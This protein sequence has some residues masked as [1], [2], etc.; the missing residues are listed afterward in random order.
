MI[1]EQGEAFFGDRVQYQPQYGYFS[2]DIGAPPVTPLDL[3][4]SQSMLPTNLLVSSPYI[5][6][7]H[8][9]VPMSPL[10]SVPYVQQGPGN[11]I[12]GYG[13]VAQPCGHRGYVY[14]LTPPPLSGFSSSN[15][16]RS[17]LDQLNISRTVVLKNLSDDLSLN[18]LL[19]VVDHGP[20]EYCK[21]FSR[22]T[23]PH[24]KDAH[25]LKTCYISFINSKLSVSFYLKYGKNPANLNSLKESL[26]N[27]KYLKVSLYEMNHNHS[28]V[29]YGHYVLNKQDF[30]KIKTLNYIVDLGATR[31]VNVNLRVKSFT[32]DD[33]TIKAF[34][35]K[36]G[37]FGE[38]EDFK[39][40]RGKD[41]QNLT[42]CIHFTSI[43]S[44]I[45]SY[46]YV[47]KLINNNT[48]ESGQ[49]KDNGTDMLVDGYIFVSFGKD[50][51]DRTDVEKSRRPSSSNYITNDSSL[52]MSQ[53]SGKDSTEHSSS[54][55]LSDVSLTAAEE[56]KNK[57]Y[58]AEG[59]D[60]ST[61]KSFK[62]LGFNDNHDISDPLLLKEDVSGSPLV[63]PAESPS[64]HPMDHT[65]ISRYPYMMQLNSHSSPSMSRSSTT[66]FSSTAFPYNPDPF[67]VGNRTIYLGNLHPSTTVEEIANNVRAGGLVESIKYHQ[68]KHMCF[69]TFVDPVVALKFY[70][71]HQVLHQL[72]IHGYSITVGW[73]KN[74]SGPLSR[75]IALAVTAGASRN[76]YIGIK[77]NKEDSDFS[78]T[79]KNSSKGRL[80]NESVL[81]RDFSK[82]G[83]L[84]QI[85]FYHNGDC[86]FLNFMHIMSAIKVVELFESGNAE[87]ISRIVGDNGKFYETY[88]DF[89][90]SFAKDRCGNPPKFNIRKKPGRRKTL[91]DEDDSKFLK[92]DFSFQEEKP[93]DN[94]SKDDFIDENAALVFGIIRKDSKEAVSPFE[95]E[96]TTESLDREEISK[97]TPARDRDATETTSDIDTTELSDLKI[98]DQFEKQEKDTTEDQK[99]ADTAVSNNQDSKKTQSSEAEEENADIDGEEYYEDDEE[100]D[101]DDDDDI[102]III[103]ANDSSFSGGHYQKPNNRKKLHEPR[104]HTSDSFV[105]KNNFSS[106]SSSNISL[107]SNDLK[108]YRSNSDIPRFPSSPYVPPPQG[109]YQFQ[110]QNRKTPNGFNN[111]Y[112]HGQQSGAAPFMS[113]MNGFSTSGS[114]VMAQYLAK[115]QHENLLYAANVLSNDVDIEDSRSSSSPYKRHSKTPKE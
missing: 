114:Q 75:E 39:I 95:K 45:K 28:G 51:C 86:G 27:S 109:L 24:I 52:A 104:F 11:H 106:R 35:T 89:K 81:R 103:G 83:E 78:S 62:P 74:H 102:S 48:A 63:D 15:G 47:M 84:E 49:K 36:F 71:N 90:I 6:G 26:N 70:L 111:Y 66:N 50:R 4:Y 16:S 99:P 40:S 55:V 14:K 25:S 107:R 46:E 80:P 56:T 110:N 2:K 18:D 5:A 7:G 44:A 42:L 17:G 38:I 8:S 108:Y 73:A 60:I 69:I 20:I 9:M 79:D 3:T 115:S 88:K 92:E 30:I 113:T 59:Q 22:P 64:T 29:G 53:F 58:E 13:Y 76:V 12:P 19:S 31:C 82:F 101:D 112:V 33:S 96:S 93:E 57:S 32:D 37:R 94:F 21:L 72:I 85:N 10:H 77:V 34:K 1:P 87:K 91:S 65:D 23:P 98:D 68:K 100:Q 105:A 41:E 67:N 97:S 54:D 43:D 61:S